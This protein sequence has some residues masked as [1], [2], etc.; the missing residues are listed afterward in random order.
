MTTGALARRV[1]RVMRR[2]GIAALALTALLIVVAC[3]PVLHPTFTV[4]ESPDGPVTFD[5]LS[6]NGTFAVVHASGAGAT[7]PG[8][9]CWRVN[10]A[11]HSVTAL[12]SCSSA[13]AISDDGS[14]I[15]LATNSGTVLW[16]SGATLTPPPATTFSKD[17]TYGV[18][19]DTDKTVKTWNAA[20]QSIGLVET[21]FPRPAGTTSAQAKAI[22]NDGRK[23]EY[24]LFGSTP[25]ERFVDLDTNTKIDRPQTI[26]VSGADSV[27]DTFSL[28]A[29]GSAFVQ[30]HEESHTDQNAS[31]PADVIDASWAELVAFP[32][33]SVTRR[34]TNTTQETIDHSLVSDNGATAWVYQQRGE[35]EGIDCQGGG[36]PFASCVVAS[37]A[38]LIANFAALTFDTGPNPIAVMHASANNAR[39][40]V[41]DKYAL[42]QAALG[43]RGPVKII[44]WAANHVETLTDHTTYTETNPTIC[45]AL[46]QSAPCTAP[47]E[48]T[49]GQV[50]DDLKVVATTTHTGKGWYEYTTSP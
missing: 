29:S 20:N 19:V 17:L 11:N 43:L 46:G 13:A 9:D 2:I 7:V 4:R 8:A 45:N 15:E 28:A 18:F 39:F 12:P 37:H 40:L 42:P 6:G 26:T 44:D 31:P 3:D 25:V 41:F 10:R 49:N 5:V 35:L 27:S 1:R 16:S 24:R 48:S 14:R 22:S 38:V 33:G 21:S 36:P 32:S 47:A 34:Y 23:V 50:S 30:V